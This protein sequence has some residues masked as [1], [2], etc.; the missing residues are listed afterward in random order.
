M[1]ENKAREIIKAFSSED[2][3]QILTNDFEAR[4]QRLISA[5]EFLGYIDDV[6]ISPK[7]RTLEEVVQRQKEILKTSTASGK[8]IFLISDFQEN[9]TNLDENTLVSSS[10]DSLINVNL[11]S[12]KSTVE[13]NLFID[14]C[15]LETPVVLLNQ[16]NSLVVRLTNTGEQ[17][18]ENSR[19]SLKVNDQI[20][21]LSDF[22]IGA[23][24]T[25]TDTVK[26][27]LSEPGFS[28]AEVLI[29]D[30]PVIFDD[31]YYLTFEVE[32]SSQILAIN[33][34]EPNQFITALFAEDNY[35]SLENKKV[36]KLDYSKFPSY[37]LIILNGLEIIPSGLAHELDEYVQAGGSITLFPGRSI[38]RQTYNSFLGKLK[39]NTIT[40]LIE[41]P[42]TL[43]K[44]NLEQAVFDEVFDDV[45]KNLLLPK[46]FLNYTFTKKTNSNEET[47]LSYADGQSFMSRYRHGQGEIYVCGAA[48]DMDFSDLPSHAL[49]VPMMYN[50]ALFSNKTGKLAYFL[51]EDELIELPDEKSS[52]ESIYKMTGKEGEFIP[53]QKSVGPS[54]L[55]DVKDQVNRSGEYV[56]SLEESGFNM[57]V[58][59]NYNRAESDLKCLEVKELKS[60]YKA[61]GFNVFESMEESITSAVKELDEGVVLW[62]LCVIFALIFLAVEILLLRFLP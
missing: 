32:E 54:V 55:I 49:F 13:K 35:F 27:T 24:A 28:K 52:A 31:S 60:R 1:A 38:D 50:V 30:H 40:G 47:M 29:E 46:T 37:S 8:F 3:F 51:G 56:L 53:G 22:D 15:W 41:K 12:L 26:F 10:E 34:Q 2:E 21:A 43:A 18:I 59:F 62:K 17:P 5:E 58:S 14:S 19:L 11:V 39:T 4:H 7:V 23:A 33:Q 25:I 42:Q 44:I 9:I 57:P 48:L 36:S 6:E 16:S 45:P 20:K 61:S